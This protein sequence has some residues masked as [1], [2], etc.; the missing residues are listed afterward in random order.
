MNYEE[1]LE[2]K[3]FSGSVLYG[4]LF[5]NL[6]FSKQLNDAIYA[7]N[8]VVIEHY[9]GRPFGEPIFSIGSSFTIG[10]GLKL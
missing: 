6:G 4:G 10:L 2:N 7:F 1:K 5:T 9:D 8:E 3:A